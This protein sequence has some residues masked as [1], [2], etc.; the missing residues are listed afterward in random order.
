MS[1]GG[2]LDIFQHLR[3]E[4][5]HWILASAEPRTISANET[6]V[7]ED[8]PSDTIFLIAD[9]LFDVLVFAG[10]QIKVGQLGPGEVIGEISW[11]D[12]KPVSATVRAAET[13]EVLALS[14]AL[15]ER[16]LAMD[17]GF[18]TRFL[19]A[20]AT[21]V[22]DRLRTT[23]SSVRRSEWEAAPRAVPAN[24]IGEG[25]VLQKIAAFKALVT[26]ADKR[27]AE[28]GGRLS[29]AD[30]AQVHAAFEA[31]EV[32][33]GSGS[34][35]GLADAMKA[36]LLPFFQLAETGNR[37]FVKP[38]GYAGDFQTI[39]M[40]NRNTPGGVGRIGRLLDG[41]LLNI[42]AA[43]AIRNRRRL[44]GAE[45]LSAFATAVKEFHVT[46]LGCGPAREIFDVYDRVDDKSRLHVTCVDIDR[47][48]LAF[49]EARSR[50]H[51]LSGYVRTRH[52]NLIYL[53]T[54]R[55]E[56]ALLPQDL[57]YSA[58]LVDSLSDELAVTLIDW[59]HGKL[60]PGGRVL[61][62]CLHPSNPSR[63]L[64]DHVLDW[65]LTHRDEAQMNELFR[66]SRFGQPCSRVVLEDVNLIAE[67]RR[68]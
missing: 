61:L 29:D 49:V 9:G 48:A 39:E 8:D 44:L 53:A 30:T 7:R 18:A 50:E 1:Y 46:S 67:C 22:A 37:Y 60:R 25:D 13:S 41:C 19:R 17:P 56:L 40:I 64:M 11:L 54:G 3:E 33:I 23:T 66:K 12:R 55:Q 26:A 32:A 6:L 28:N 27:A 15:L 35:V 20:V 2:A 68:Q 59:I 21:L 43:K 10:H 24:P 65:R 47:E 4:D 5:A 51:G 14:T 34:A 31:L 62:G 36:E 52:A 45:I 38:R 58:G 16:K 42:A 63:G 57:I